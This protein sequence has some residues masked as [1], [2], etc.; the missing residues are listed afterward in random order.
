MDMFNV[1]SDKVRKNAVYISDNYFL[2]II[3]RRHSV[4]CIL[5]AKQSAALLLSITPL[6]E[7]LKSSFDRR[8]MK[9]G[10]CYFAEFH[11]YSFENQIPSS[12]DYNKHTHNTPTLITLPCSLAGMGKHLFYLCEIAV[13]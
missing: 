3:S 10:A 8:E 12:L 13:N 5:Q 6:D 4:L 7:N 2:I 1:N 11:H 9:P